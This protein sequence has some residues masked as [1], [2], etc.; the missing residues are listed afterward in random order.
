MRRTVIAGTGSHVPERVVPNAHFADHV[1]RGRDGH[2]LSGANADL[3]RQF[4]TITG[5]RERRWAA[6]DLTASDLGADA[7]RQ[8]LQEIEL[9]RV[10]PRFQP[11]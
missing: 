9:A 8:A 10:S 6:D 7:A 3:L 4:E 1:F 5:I 11:S 2:A